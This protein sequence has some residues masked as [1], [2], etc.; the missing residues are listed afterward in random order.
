VIND[1]RPD[2][3]FGFDMDPTHGAVA[4]TPPV[5]PSS[6][7]ARRAIASAVVSLI[8]LV[9]LMRVLRRMRR[10]STAD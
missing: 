10:S 1:D 9:A 2:S 3:D 5:G 7:R 4:L 8:G 6:D